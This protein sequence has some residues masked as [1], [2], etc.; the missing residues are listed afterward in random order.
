MMKSLVDNASRWLW[1]TRAELLPAWQAGLLH[2]CRLLY[3]G[4]RD[5]I[6]GELNLRAMSLVYTSLLSI[7]PLLALT[8]SVLKAFNVHN[9]VEPFLLSLLAPLGDKAPSLVEQL[10]GFVG[11]VKVGVLGGVGLGLL[12]YT[13]VALLQKTAFAFDY[14]WKV[15]PTAR[16]AK[17]FSGYFGVITLGP[18]IIFTAISSITDF[19]NSGGLAE[20]E[21]IEPLAT[22]LWIIG[23]VLPYLLMWVA[24][25]AIYTYVPNTKVKLIPA[26]SGA[27]VAAVLWESSGS[28]FAAFVTTSRNYD[29]IYSGFAAG[30]LFLIWIYLGW[31]I[32]LLGGAFSFYVQNP[33]Y[34]RY[35]RPP[36]K[37]SGW[38]KERVGLALM[39][40]IARRHHRREKPW[41]TDA[42]AKHMG[43]PRLPVES[44]LRQF[45]HRDMVSATNDY[46]ARWLL[47]NDPARLPVVDILWAIRRH[48]EDHLPLS[49]NHDLDIV[50]QTLESLEGKLHS[51]L[52]ERVLEDLVQAETT[53]PEKKRSLS[54]GRKP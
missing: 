47:N 13:V 33:Q 15:S 41:T 17:R 38:Q 46:P 48:G 31:M 11:N 50:D 29:V 14:I 3:A 10:I 36:E 24:F 23:I 16:I 6:E 26:L 20:W 28:I 1:E 27:A 9:Q 2:F 22:L 40:L 12:I 35:R 25:A 42:L 44:L 37:L 54:W 53:E 19:T 34:L 39:T 43:L 5:L 49:A 4:I 8:F 21:A 32:L 52:E 7:V 51:V 30:I 45:K 18:V